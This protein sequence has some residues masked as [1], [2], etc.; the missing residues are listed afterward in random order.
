[1]LEATYRLSRAVEIV[2]NHVSCTEVWL[3]PE[4]LSRHDVKE[5]FRLL[6]GLEP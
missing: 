5:E 3:I 1:M 6:S 2:A 4:C